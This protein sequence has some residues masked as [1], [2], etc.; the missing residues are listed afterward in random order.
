MTQMMLLSNNPRLDRQ[1]LD[2]LAN[3]GHLH[4]GQVLGNMPG[5]RVPLE[6]ANEESVGIGKEGRHN[7]AKKVEQDGLEDEIHNVGGETDHHR[8]NLVLGGAVD[9]ENGADHSDHH[10]GDYSRHDAVRRTLHLVEVVTHN[11]R[12]VLDGL[13][14]DLIVLNVLVEVG[15]GVGQVDGV[16]GDGAT[17]EDQ[18]EGNGEDEG[19]DVDPDDGGAHVAAA[20]AAVG[21]PGSFLGDD[22]GSC[23]DS[24]VVHAHCW[25]VCV[26]SFFW[27]MDWKS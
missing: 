26:C 11:L 27:L 22:G 8:P 19:D 9:T 17:D 20:A 4:L 1:G 3:F 24:V 13:I 5:V 25:L 23:G 10:D 7:Q 12:H 2:R 6:L 14:A 18:G 16:H 21:R 15:V